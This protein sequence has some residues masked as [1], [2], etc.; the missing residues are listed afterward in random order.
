[1]EKYLELGQIVN[2]FGIRGQVKV[3][4]FTDDIKK[5][6]TFKEIFVEKKNLIHITKTTIPYP[7]SIGKFPW[8]SFFQNIAPSIANAKAII[9]YIPADNIAFLFIAEKFVDSSL[10]SFRL[11]IFS[12]LSFYIILLN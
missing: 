8:S 5:F 2:T 11:F 4:P 12:F 9:V 1:M 7:Y 10:F 3:K 6:D